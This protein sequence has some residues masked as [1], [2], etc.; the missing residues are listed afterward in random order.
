MSEMLFLR[1]P[2]CRYGSQS[3]LLKFKYGFEYFGGENDILSS[4]KGL[5]CSISG[6]DF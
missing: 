5:L 3:D 6:G 1:N 4:Y 2:G